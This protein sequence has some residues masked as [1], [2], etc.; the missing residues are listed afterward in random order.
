M[1]K[2]Q[3]TVTPNS[4]ERPASKTVKK[5]NRRKFLWII[6]V[7][8]AILI[9][10]AA[11]VYG[12]Y[13]FR[14]N[15]KV[16]I[17]QSYVNSWNDLT[18]QTTIAGTTPGETV[19]PD[20]S[21]APT[22]TGVEEGP[23]TLA[24]IDGKND[25]IIKIDPIDPN[26]ENILIIGIDG[27]DGL[28]IGHRSDTMLIVSINKEKK[29]V[30]LTSLMRDIWAYFP[31]R[32]AWD[33]INAS[34]AYGGPGQTV[35]I[36]NYNFKLDIQKYVIT[37]FEGFRGIVNII[38]GTEIKV[39]DKEAGQIAGLTS[40]GTYVLDGTQTLSYARIRHIDSDF[41]RVQ[42]QR[43]VL[44]SIFAGLRKESTVN[45]IQA[46]NDSLEFMR[47]NI[48]ATD[49]TGRLFGL[50]LQIDSSIDQRTIPESGMYTVHDSG[51]WYMS[52]NWEKQVASLHEFIYGAS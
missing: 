13:I 12:Y 15:D 2:K 32:D 49:I 38:G 5:H 20:A 44:L 37:D 18:G 27:G 29:T 24:D 31:N 25:P 11:S 16:A 42:R 33:K 40:G 48:D 19:S 52:L 6:A 22:P 35:N 46:A 41:A 36:V 39:T 9:I 34:Y 26:I 28:N 51:T 10:L 21:Q 50:A 3:S 4:T 17:D 1:K 45:Q 8:P 14:Y 43:T 7:I 30:K 47:S 23:A